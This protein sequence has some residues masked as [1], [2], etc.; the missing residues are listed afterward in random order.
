MKLLE[1]NS[2]FWRVA[3]RSEAWFRKTVQRALE[4]CFHGALS[5]YLAVPLLY[6]AQSP[7]SAFWDRIRHVIDH[8]I[9]LQRHLRDS[10][11][12]YPDILIDRGRNDVAMHLDFI[13]FSSALLFF[14]IIITLNNIKSFSDIL[15]KA[16][17]VIGATEFPLAVLWWPQHGPLFR[18]DIMLP[19]LALAL[20]FIAYYLLRK[21][22]N[23]VFVVLA[24][25]AHI[26]MWAWSSGIWNTWY[27]RDL[28]RISDF[29]ERFPLLAVTT[30]ILW[31][32]SPRAGRKTD[33][34]GWPL[35]HSQQ[36]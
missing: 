8:L 36:S 19:E 16:S 6:L 25:I 5:I 35:Q 29:W 2:R 30:I 21:R 27:V 20:A 26:L 13:I 10:N 23:R 22:P 3:A 18:T 11:S 32:V 1:S 31:G 34:A 4:C 17:G 15:W 28:G 7:Q 24:L 12:T 9:D 33:A 14:V